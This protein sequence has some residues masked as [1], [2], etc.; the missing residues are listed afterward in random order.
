[1]HKQEKALTGMNSMSDKYF[2]DTNIFVYCFDEQKPDKKS[3]ALSLISDALQTGNGIISTQVIQ[4]F[5]NVATRK[6]LIPLMR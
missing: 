2:I 4:E 6:F 5:L 3:R 1:M